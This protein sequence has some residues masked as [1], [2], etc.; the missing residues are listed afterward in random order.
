MFSFIIPVLATILGQDSF[1]LKGSIQADLILLH[2]TVLHRYW[3]FFSPYKWKVCG[4]SAG[5]I[6]PMAFAQV[7]SVSRAAALRAFRYYHSHSDH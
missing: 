7:M 5:T 6:F 2:L 1:T 3:G 4:K